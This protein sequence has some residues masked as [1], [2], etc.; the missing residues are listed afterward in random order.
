MLDKIRNTNIQ[1]GEAGGIT[2]QIGATFFP[3]KKL[4]RG[5]PIVTKVRALLTL[6]PMKEIRVKG[7]YIHDDI[8]YESIGLK[9]LAVGLEDAMAGSQIYLANSQEDIDKATK[10]VNNEME[11]VKKYIKLQNQGVG[12]AAS[13]LGSLEALLQYLNSQVIPVSYVSVGP[14]SKDEVMKALKNV[15]LEDL[16]RRKKEYIYLFFIDMLLCWF[17]MQKHCQML[18]NL[19]R[20]MKSRLLKQTSFIIYQLSLQSLQSKSKKK[21]KKKEATDFV[22]P[23]LLKIVRIINTK[24]PLILGVE[25]EQGILKTGTPICIYDQNSNK[26]KIGI[27]ETIELNHKSLKEARATKVALRIGTNQAI[28][29]GKQINLET[30]EQV[31][32]LLI[33]FPQITRRAIYILKEH[34][35]EDITLDDWQLV[36]DLKLFQT[37]FEIYYIKQKD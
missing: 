13:T 1:E 10:I 23:S 14:V 18:R 32:Y 29:A 2:Q 22:F 12:V 6:N 24:E 19:V 17:S 20:K 16:N 15:L 8:I 26:N 31:W 3:E 4:K 27:V 7:E 11:E 34:Y 36:K 37:L 33:S 21:E 28:Q 35:R 9:I 25:V 5:L 30:N